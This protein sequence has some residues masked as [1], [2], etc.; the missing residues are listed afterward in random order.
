ADE[1]AVRAAPWLLAALLTGNPAL[2]RLPPTVIENALITLWRRETRMTTRSSPVPASVDRPD[3]AGRP[4]TGTPQPTS[5]WPGPP[6]QVA[7][8]RPVAA[9][10]AT[11]IDGSDVDSTSAQPIL[12]G[13]L[14]LLIRPLIAAA[15]L[16]PAEELPTALADLA[17][18]ALRRVL[19]TLPRGERE[20]AEEGERP[21]LTVFA[22]QG[23]W[24]ERIAGRPIQRPAAA[25]R[26][27]EALLAQVPVDLAAV[28]GAERRLFGPLLGSHPARFASEAERRLARL[29]LR[30]GE[31]RVNRWQAEMFWPLSAVDPLLRR[32]GWDQDPGWVPWLGR[33]IVFHFGV[34]P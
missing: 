26:L 1:T 20:V 7:P 2:S 27:L 15:L 29:L 19:S 31:L 32:A 22:P 25:E 12:F 11:V 17:L 10:G 24:R 13:G 4:V 21:L 9:I 14:L 8:G 5:N 34:T 18:L 30:P 16:P 33:R 28:A 6:G 3:G 23:D